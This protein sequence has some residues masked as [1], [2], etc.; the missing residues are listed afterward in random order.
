MHCFGADVFKQTE[1]VFHLV[2][3][4]VHRILEAANKLVH[5]AEAVGNVRPDK[6]CDVLETML[7][8]C[9]DVVHA[10]AHVENLLGG[11]CGVLR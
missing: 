6:V 8:A 2:V 1:D 5:V 11:V 10:T 4:G 7:Y 9:D 3:G